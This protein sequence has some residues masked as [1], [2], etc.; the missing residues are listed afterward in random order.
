MFEL[1]WL[2]K[3]IV[4]MLCFVPFIF[5]FNFFSKNYGM[6]P[7]VLMVCWYIG[8]SIGIYL[9]VLLN[10]IPNIETK[11]FSLNM[12]VLYIILAGIVIGTPMNILI[13]QS[14]LQAPNPGLP[15]TIINSGSVLAY[16]FAP[17]I[18]ILLPQYFE[19]MTFNWYQFGGIGL[20]V[21]GIGI[22][23]LKQS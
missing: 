16:M 15:F 12:P 21:V 18:S 7:E 23:T 6:K 9:S 5:A 17:V 1:G 19:K 10:W 2:G 3:A 20:I 22:V 8:V 13:G 4:A 11:D 14:A